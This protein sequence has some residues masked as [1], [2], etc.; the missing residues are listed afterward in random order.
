MEINV[1]EE[2]SVD[3]IVNKVSK[4]F[5]GILRTN[6]YETVLKDEEL[7]KL[8]RKKALLREALKNSGI[9]DL[10]A[11]NYV[12]EA[13]RSILEDKLKINEDNIDNI[14]NFANPY[15]MS[16]RD[17][18]DII[19]HLYKKVYGYDGLSQIIK[20]YDIHGA[21]AKDRKSVV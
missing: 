10:H 6:L 21:T 1:K 4:E 8:R 19:L 3:E 15:K 18:F 12:K 2:Y 5:G 11:K 17:K 13:I 14:I 7:K 9:G 16:A 20:E